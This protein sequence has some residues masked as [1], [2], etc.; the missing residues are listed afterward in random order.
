MAGRDYA[1]ARVRAMKGRLLGRK[2]IMDLLAQPD[3]A[4]QMAKAS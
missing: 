2:G 1:N 4:E 3:L